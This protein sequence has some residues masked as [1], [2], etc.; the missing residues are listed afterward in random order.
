MKNIVSLLIAIS[1]L[2][3]ALISC[4]P[5]NPSDGENNEPANAGLEFELSEDGTYYS[6]KSIV[7]CTDTELVIPEKYKDL[8][9]TTIGAW[10]LSY[11][12]ELTSVVIPD[13]V[14]TIGD[15]A[16]WGCENLT[17][18]VIPDSVTT[19]GHNAFYKCAGLTSVEIHGGVTTMGDA[20][21]AECS[22]IISAVIGEGITTICD[23][24]FMGCTSLTSVVIPSSV[25]IIGA[26]AFAGCENLASV[27][28]PDSVTTID[29]TTFSNCDSL[30]SIVIHEGITAIAPFAFAGC[31]SLK[32]II[33]DEDNQYFKSIDGNLYTTDGKT[34]MRYA[35]GKKDSNFTIQDS[36]TTI[37]ALAFEACNNLTSV[38]IPNGVTTIGQFAFSECNSLTDLYYMGSEEEWANI[39]TY[40][41]SFKPEG[42]EIHYNYVPEN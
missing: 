2:L 15:A 23:S 17:S 40:D 19:I 11:C 6:V 30:T 42:V 26:A 3:F 22:G 9:V 8:P 29:H 14:T 38:V 35:I 7:T 37:G 31:E 13:S 34:L 25:S 39:T 18:V 32:E 41:N 20:V 10:A 27:E 28:I 5:K 16:F 24:M 33:V 1:L 4:S 36:V 21:F 12:P